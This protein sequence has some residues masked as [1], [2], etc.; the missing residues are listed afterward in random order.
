[1]DKVLGL[2]VKLEHLLHFAAKI[3]IRAAGFVEKCSAILWLTLQRSLED[4]INFSPAVGFH[5]LPLR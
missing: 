5:L 3:S 2:L 4:F 1:L